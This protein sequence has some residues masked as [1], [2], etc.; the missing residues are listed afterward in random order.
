MLNEEN[1]KQS[2]SKV[3]EDMSLLSKEVKL[4]KEVITIQNEAIKRLS[5]SISDLS[6]RINKI[7]KNL[8]P[9]TPENP[10]NHLINQSF[11]H[12]ITNQ[13]PNQQ[14]SLKEPIKPNNEVSIGNNGVNQSFNHLINQQ[15]INNQSFNQPN[16]QITLQDPNFLALRSNLEGIFRR[17]SKQELKLFLTVYQ[18]EDEKNE[19]N[20]TNIAQKMELSE[21]CIRSHISALIKK[22]AP[23]IKK[24][25][26]NRTNLMFIRPD[27]K[28]LNL[29]QRLINMFYETD[30]YQTTLF[31]IK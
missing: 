29:K 9:K 26:N 2:F 25:L 3:K 4:Q 17:L 31:D 6:L 18:L 15:S 28:A 23:L 27:F 12:L 7:L 22:N 13:S 11:N 5:Q 30:P 8:E 14:N 10:P 19:T 16:N 24:R 21:H 20:Y 1:I